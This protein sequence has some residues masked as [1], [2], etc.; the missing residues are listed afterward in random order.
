MDPVASYERL[1]APRV[2]GEVPF[3]DASWPPCSTWNRVHGGVRAR[4]HGA[5]FTGRG[6][7]VS[8]RVP[9]SADGSARAG[10]PA[11]PGDVPRGTGMGT[12]SLR[13]SPPP[14][15][16]AGPWRLEHVPRGT[17]VG[18][19]HPPLRVR[20][21]VAPT[22][23]S[24]SA[25]RLGMFHVEQRC[26]P[27]RVSSSSRLGPTNPQWAV[28]RGASHVPRGTPVSTNTRRLTSPRQPHQWWSARGGSAHVPRGTSLSANTRRFVFAMR[29]RRPSTG[30]PR[31][32]H[33]RSTWNT[34]QHR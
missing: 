15:S 24:A 16:V 22:I 7:L 25:W 8:A 6:S 28:H 27:A 4:A 30:T 26:A 19:Q 23:G 29:L 21:G 18:V 2:S 31:R 13:W 5:G 17:T 11:L 14:A 10:R 33:A 32:S 1:L 12:A 9:P 34:A 20:D 3:R